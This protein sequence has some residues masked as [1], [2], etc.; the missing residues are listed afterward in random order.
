MDILKILSRGAKKSSKASAHKSGTVAALKLPSAGTEAN[1]Q[2]FHDD[3]GS[4]RKRKRTN[5]TG[6]AHCKKTAI[7]AS[8]DTKNIND[9]DLPELDFF[10]PKPDDTEDAT[11]PDEG[12][13]NG[14]SNDSE[15]ESEDEHAHERL[16]EEECKSLL[17]SHRLKVTLLSKTPTPV[18]PEKK[19]K[20]S[21]KGKKGE[22]EA[23][24]STPAKKD[25]KKRLYPEPLT[26]FATLRTTYK[27]SRRL[28]ENIAHQAYKIPTEVQMGALPLLVN[29]RRALSDAERQLLTSVDDQEEPVGVDLL[30][31]APTGSG[32]TLSFLIPAINAMASRRAKLPKPADNVEDFHELEVVVLAPTRELGYQIVNEAR[33]LTQGMGLRVAMMRKGMRIAAD[34]GVEINLEEE[35]EDDEDGSSSDDGDEEEDEDEDEDKDTPKGV[36]KVDILVTTPMPLLNFLRKDAKD[37]TPM[38][39]PTVRSL[40]LDEADVLLDQLFHEQTTGVWKSCTYSNLQHSLWSA[41]MGSN[42]ETMV[43]EALEARRAATNAPPKP[44]VRLVVGLKDTAVPNIK[45]KLIF[46]GSE[47][48]KIYAIRQLL[49]PGSR[50]DDTISIRPPFI[51]FTQSIERAAALQDELR[52]DIPLEAGGSARIAALHSGLT[53][54]QRASIMRQFRAGEIWILI[55]TDVLARGVDFAGVNGVVNYD[56]PG[57]SAVYIHRAGRTGRAGRE[58]GIAVTL[59]TKDDIPYVKVIANVIAASDKQAGRVG[60]DLGVPESLLASLPSVSKEDKKKLRERGVEARRSGG[61]SSKI[62]T[63]SGWERQRM[64][65]REAAVKHS[66]RM[67]KEE[68]R[69]RATDK[70]GENEEWGGIDD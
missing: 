6:D 24:E 7:A 46:T 8:V 22:Q 26:S 68:K 51:V 62:T 61:A 34:K 5:D 20:K 4:S 69:R 2:L 60:E 18:L 19:S 1:P 41:T 23:K 54:A 15:T 44:L 49:R 33:K 11:G 21:K 42:I 58:G 3:L 37:G 63:K 14:K 28:A 10:A 55:T 38:T 56:I 45:H 52:Y 64:N 30:A 47:M 32:K 31:V 9:D 66:K 65:N 48:G 53:D 12:A 40:I 16:S 36:T 25:D 29:A 39:L 59:W 70:T 50:S 35:E 27:I 57:S 43:I 13:E 67:R 17:H